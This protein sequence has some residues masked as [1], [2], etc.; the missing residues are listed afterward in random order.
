MKDR[1]LLVGIMADSHGRS[2]SIGAA[3]EAFRSLGCQR[4]HHLGDV[5]DSM[6][7]Q[8]ADACV[9]LLVQANVFVVKGNNDHAVVVNQWGMNTGLVREDVLQYLKDLPKSLEWRG[10]DFAHSLPFTKEMGLSAMVGPMTDAQTL[11]YFSRKKNGLF[12]RGHSHDPAAAFLV[13]G[14]VHSQSLEPG[15]TLPLEDRLPCVVTCG[16]LTRGYATL[17]NPDACTITCLSIG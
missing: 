3:L 5:C 14:R 8:T 4:V 16:A 10:A 12:F 15:R 6:I 9:D 1:S 17:W 13:N 7:P 11:R 2:E